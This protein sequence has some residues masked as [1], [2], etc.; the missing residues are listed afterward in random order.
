MISNITK[1]EDILTNAQNTNNCKQML[2]FYKSYQL[3]GNV[4]KCYQQLNNSKQMLRIVNKYKQQLTVNSVN[5][6]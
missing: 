1:F 3:W 6:S 5:Y 2:T 4:N